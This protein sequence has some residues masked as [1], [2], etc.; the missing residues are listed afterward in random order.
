MKKKLSLSEI[1]VKSFITTPQ[2]KSLNGGGE[3]TLTDN[4]NVQATYQVACISQKIQSLCGS[5]GIQCTD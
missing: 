5:C 3:N 2:M 4:I 1:S